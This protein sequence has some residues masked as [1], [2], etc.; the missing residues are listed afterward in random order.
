MVK[1][2]LFSVE[3]ANRTLPLVR[4]ITQDIVDGY[5]DLLEARESYRRLRQSIAG[6]PSE[7]QDEELRSLE[8]TADRR[9]DRLEDCLRELAMIGCQ[10]KDFETGLIDFPAERDGRPIL[11]CW[12]LG[13]ETVEYWHTLEGGFRGRQPI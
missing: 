10:L 7:S 2:K 11:L 4:K 5:T 9:Q 13:E 8:D 6:Q 1:Q 12:R 3:Q